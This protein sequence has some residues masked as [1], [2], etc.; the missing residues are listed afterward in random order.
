MGRF[1]REY[2]YQECKQYRHCLCLHLNRTIV[3][4]D[5]TETQTLYAIDI[6]DEDN[7]QLRNYL[8]KLDTYG[9]IKIKAFSQ[10]GNP[11]SD[12][13][14]IT[15]NTSWIEEIEQIKNP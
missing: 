5:N 14:L 12:S 15:I 8:Y 3:L 4:R 7:S 11:I 1:S 9:E 13:F 2:L 6:I 10:G